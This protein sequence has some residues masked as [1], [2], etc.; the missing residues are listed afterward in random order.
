MAGQSTG[1]RVQ[2]AI[3][4]TTALILVAFGVGA[5][6]K[7]VD[8]RSTVSD[9][10]KAER[11]QG[12]PFM[13]PDGIVARS[14][15]LGFTDFEA[16]TCSVA[17]KAITTGADARC[18]AE[19]MRI[20]ALVATKGKTYADMPSFVAKDGGLTSE[21]A[22]AKTFPAGGPVPNPARNVWITETALTTALNTSYMAEQI[23]L[24]GI[25][26]GAM[27]LLVGLVIGGLALGGFQ[28]GRGQSAQTRTAET[29]SRT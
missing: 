22:E 10:L 2:R 13:S 12:E 23:S 28:V 24:F 5:I 14:K 6:V 3:A 9:S 1:G 7:G 19:Y 27:L 17:S 16:P 11:S 8:G 29:L 21:Y 25:G 26:V 18:F 20:D 4:L 15:A